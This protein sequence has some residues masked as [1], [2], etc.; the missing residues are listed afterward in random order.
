MGGLT[1]LVAVG[2][3][4]AYISSG[5]AAS[6]WKRKFPKYKNFSLESI[7]QTLNG[8]VDYGQT[9]SCIVA[10]NGDL[11]SNVVLEIELQRGTGTTYYPTEQLI[12]SVDL[13]IGGQKIDTI[14]HEWFRMYYEMFM[15]VDQ[16]HAY[17]NMTDFGM[18][19]EGYIRKFYLPIPFWFSQLINCNAIP[20][21]ALQ[22][23][24]VQLNFTLCSKGNIPGIN[25]SFKPKVEC[26]VDY[27]FLD[28]DERMQF[29]RNSH[30]Y[31]ITQLQT[32]TENIRVSNTLNTFRIPMN[33]NHPVKCV[34]WALTP[35]PQSH[36]QYTA[37]PG[38]QDAEILAPLE[39]AS[40]QF[41]GID[42][43]VRR[44][45]SYFTK[46]N[47]WTSAKGSYLSSGIYFYGFGLNVNEYGP[48]G[49]MN[50][51][52][53]DNATLSLTTKKAIVADRTASAV[54]DETMTV[55]DSNI[56]NT[57]VVFAY[58]YNVLKIQSGMG[59]M[60]FAN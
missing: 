10:R 20:L 42:R 28:S 6:I 54:V 26:W 2:V 32:M 15:T 44:S 34:M 46:M 52:R 37:V 45:G 47:P 36:G 40:M 60:M 3:Q 16:E 9:V 53:I 55:V 27:V 5:K 13:Y 23:H 38:E 19:P 49:T 39:S 35:G 30:E 57:I 29:A 18:E 8:T 4:D 58:N 51:S 43:F 7:R 1:Q 12:D 59:G 14:T 22:Y 25:S 31:L 48:R 56:L 41:N 33:F 24:E 17:Q 11:M 21:I 50:F